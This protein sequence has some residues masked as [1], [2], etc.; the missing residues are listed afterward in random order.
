M[1]RSWLSRLFGQ[2][3]YLMPA[4]QDPTVDQL[5]EGW[6]NRRGTGGDGGAWQW[7]QLLGLA[8]AFAAILYFG[9]R[10]W[11][12]QAQASG[13]PTDTP[14]APT[15]NGPALE[16]VSVQATAYPTRTPIVWPTL[17]VLR[18]TPTPGGPAATSTPTDPPAATAVSTGGSSPT[19]ESATSSPTV[20]PSQTARVVYQNSGGGGQATVVVYVTQPPLPTY[21]PRPTYTPLPTYTVVPTL[22]V[23]STATSSPEPTA[24]CPAPVSAEPLPESAHTLYLPLIYGSGPALACQP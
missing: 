20:A 6:S 2:K 10:S 5:P 18:L 1:K 4:G 13:L 19:L 23:T 11:T 9:I 16:G 3:Y 14:P 22:E 8:G 7:L 24:T 21:T 17:G 12:G 15:A